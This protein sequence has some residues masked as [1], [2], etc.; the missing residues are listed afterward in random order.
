LRWGGAWNAQERKEHINALEMLAVDI[1][2]KSVTKDMNKI[3]VHVKTDN[4]TTV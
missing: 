4:A 1:A 3:H 2:V